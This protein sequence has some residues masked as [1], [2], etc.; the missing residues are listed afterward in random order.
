MPD[1]SIIGA[2]NVSGIISTLGSAGKL[3]LWG[4]AAMGI[5]YI[6]IYF[7]KY[8][9]KLYLLIQQGQA[10]RF[11]KDRGKADKSNKVFTALKNR[12]INFPYPETKYEMVEG[13]GSA[14][15]AFVKNQSATFLEVSEN[16]HFVP[17][18]YNMQ[19]HL[20]KMYI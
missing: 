8:N 16:P 6:F 20:I 17:A 1:M 4:L 7:V 13:R 10:V 12:D 19:K 3:I 5:I 2:K 9:K 15:F 18:N 14:L 11:V